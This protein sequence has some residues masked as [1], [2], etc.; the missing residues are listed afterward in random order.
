MRGVALGDK[1]HIAE[2]T[3]HYIKYYG[4]STKR[5][6]SS[7]V[8]RFWRTFYNRSVPLML[9]FLSFQESKMK[10]KSIMK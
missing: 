9:L 8:G 4:C 3:L 10:K 7:G 5:N 2:E 6:N 1:Y